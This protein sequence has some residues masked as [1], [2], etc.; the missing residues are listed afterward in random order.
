MWY[1]IKLKTFALLLVY[2]LAKFFSQI[3]TTSFKHETTYNINDSFDF[4]EKVKDLSLP[5]KYIFLS[6][7]A[8]S[9]FTT[10]PTKLVIDIINEKWNL[11]SVNC[12]LDKNH[13]VEGIKLIFENVYFSFQNVIYLQ[14]FGTPMGSPLSPIIAQICLDYLFNKTIPKLP[15]KVPFIYKY[16]DDIIT[17]IPENEKENILKFFNEFNEYIQFTIEVEVNKSIAFLDTII[18]RNDTNR[19]IINWYTKPTYSGRYINFNSDHSYQ[20]KVNTILAIKNRV[21]KISDETF[22]EEN[23]NKIK[24]TFKKNSYPTSIINKICNL[25]NET[26][27]NNVNENII[28][29]KLT[30]IPN[31]S[32]SIKKILLEYS[33]DLNIAFTYKH[34]LK[35]LFTKLKDSDKVEYSSNIIYSIPCKNCNQKYIGMTSQWLKSRVAI[36][37][38]DYK[39]KLPRCALSQHGMSNLHI[40]DFNYDKIQVLDREQNLVKRKFLEMCHIQ[41]NLNTVCNFKN[42]TENL[43]A[44]YGNLINNV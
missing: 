8:V 39:L 25:N 1:N 13:F 34:K 22:L 16:V 44:I 35:S 15:Y 32:N 2:L 36:H 9:L 41:K 6:L 18:T 7:D 29:K 27:I 4:V 10:I 11:I 24:D 23:L 31:L 5:D 14:I 28:Y 30:Y 21:V 3:L 17:S 19:V 20:H 40:F 33:T 43:N 26:R 12:N 42:D 37:K 38:S